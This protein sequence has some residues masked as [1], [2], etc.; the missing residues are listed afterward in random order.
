V[1]AVNDVSF[2]LRRGEI[3]G[4]LGP[5]GAGKSTTIRM[6][7]GLV[8]P[9]AGSTRILDAT[10]AAGAPVL[11]RVGAIVEAAAFYPFLSGR[12]NLQLW[13]QTAGRRDP[14]AIR[15]ALE[16]AELG[17]AADRRVKTYSHG[18]RE[19]LGIAR[20]LMERPD[21]LVLDEPA[22]GLDPSG[23]RAVRG[24]LEAAAHEGAAILLSSHLLAEVELLCTSVVVMR[25]GAVVA[26][27]DLSDLLAART[28]VFDVED[29]DAAARRQELV[30]QRGADVAG[31][32]G[33]DDGRVDHVTPP[34]GCDT[35]SSSA[36]TGGAPN[37][38]GARSNAAAARSYSAGVPMSN[39]SA[40]LWNAATRSPA[41]S[42]RST[43]SGNWHGPSGRW[44]RARS[45]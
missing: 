35:A 20:A 26:R 33:H 8:R 38:S 22:T 25:A 7:L 9:D 10:I 23:I 21:V 13:Q 6:M 5:N 18:M 36:S 31:T 3:C 37:F 2:A 42:R 17:S 27:A 32:P 34:D 43:R 19:R 12:R 14:A 29:A 24:L 15:R 16:V 41:A 40:S 28:S 1:R 4:L 39:H 45:S 11:S 44:R 30:A